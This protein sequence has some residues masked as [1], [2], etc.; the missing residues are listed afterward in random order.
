[1]VSA[2]REATE[3]TNEQTE[4]PQAHNRALSEDKNTDI[5]NIGVKGKTGTTE[6]SAQGAASTKQSRTA[7]TAP[8]QQQQNQ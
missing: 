3:Q 5:A 6:I 8:H 1:M 2:S 4:V 7:A